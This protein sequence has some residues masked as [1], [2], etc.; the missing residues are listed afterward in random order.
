MYDGEGE[1]RGSQQNVQGKE[2]AIDKQLPLLPLQ[3]YKLF[4][5]VGSYRD[6][7]RDVRIIS[8]ID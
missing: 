2:R 5:C 8:F 6:L 4:K 1:E 7:Y 3:H